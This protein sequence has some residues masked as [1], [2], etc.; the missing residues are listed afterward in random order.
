[1]T[2]HHR[3]TAL[4]AGQEHRTGFYRNTGKRALDLFLIALFALPAAMITLVLAALIM[5]DGASPFYLQDRLGRNGKVF[6]IWK[7][8]SMVVDADARLESYLAAHPEARVEWN[9]KQKLRDDP[10]VTRIGRIIRKTS[11]DELP[12]LWNVIRGDMSLVGPRPMLP[13][14]RAL[15]PGTAYFDVRP[16]V[17][18]YWQTSAR[19]ESSFAERARFDT[20]YDRD[21]SL[22]TDL[23][24]LW[25][26][27]DVVIKGTGC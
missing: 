15:Y 3:Q 5:L 26:S 4:H 7:L 25:R 23:A 24:V 12:Q 21:L 27:V 11:L 20:A 1:M 10:R 6:R 14:Q 13:E 16:G 22:R 18:G 9:T 2:V 17:T 8:R 19:N